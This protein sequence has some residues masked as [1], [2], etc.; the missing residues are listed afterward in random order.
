MNLSLSRQAALAVPSPEPSPGMAPQLDLHNPGPSRRSGIPTAVTSTPGAKE[1]AHNVITICDSSPLS[2][3]ES[4]P[5][6]AGPIG[7]P[8]D[9][10][11]VKQNSGAG[12]GYWPPHQPGLAAALGV[13]M[14]TP[15]PAR[16]VTFGSQAESE[17]SSGPGV[18]TPPSGC[19]G[20]SYFGPGR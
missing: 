1:T 8:Q 5:L 2:S 11:N 18:A 12:A 13:G 17:T 16:R 20:K 14:T 19:S 4:S 9:K 7:R 10:E 15:A 3:K 6:R